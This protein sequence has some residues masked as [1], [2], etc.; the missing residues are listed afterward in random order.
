MT[1][2]TRHMIPLAVALLTLQGADA[3]ARVTD[4]PAQAPQVLNNFVTEVLR[5]DDLKGDGTHHFTIENPRRG[6]LFFRTNA[7]AGIQGQVELQIRTRGGDNDAAIQVINYEPGQ[8]ARLEA[9][10]FLDPGAYTVQLRM[11]D[12]EVDSLEVRLIPIINYER[13]HGSFQG[14]VGGYPEYD[15]EFL[16]RCGMLDSINTIGTYDGFKWIREWQESGKQAIRIAGGHGYEF[17]NGCMDSYG[18][19]GIIIDE[20]YPGVSKHFPEWAEALKRV[21]TNHPEKLCLLYLAGGAPDL[22]ALI[23]PLKDLDFYI[24]PEEQVY[25]TPVTEEELVT[26]GF[27]RGWISGFRDSY[28]PNVSSRTVHSIGVYSGPSKSKY[29][30]DVYADRSW[31]V[32]RELHFH[33]LATDPVHVGAGG[34]EIYQ[35]TM[36]DEEYLRWIARLFRHYAIEGSSERL[37]Q[38][39]YVLD[40]IEN[41]DFDAGLEGWTVESATDDSV[42]VKH[43]DRYGVKVQGRHA[44]KGVG[45]HVLW[46]K[47]HAERPNVVTQEIRDLEPGRYYCV[48]MYSGDYQNLHQWQL[49]NLAFRVG[50]PAIMMPQQCFQTVWRH[51]PA[52]E[53]GNEPTFQNFHRIV[54][55]ARSETV[56]LYISDWLNTYRHGTVAT[57]P[58]GQEVIVNFIQVEPY[59]MPRWLVE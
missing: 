30:D 28:F 48:K 15:R 31:K 44:P 41:P 49:N 21:K 27:A 33:E 58:V 6:W 2:P 8:R 42:Q 54:F 40:H 38:D 57:A 12:A 39:P 17:W 5:V 50:D 32:H 4:H 59:L 10:R 13:F 29:N 7:V 35:S 52:E 20:F 25:E 19:N 53:F 56:T 1:S 14:M 46:M 24:T 3:R 16:T 11:K 43:L 23:E 18:V 37:T 34:V 36:C 55:R 22:Q 45:D 47:R 9:M 51:N 26:K